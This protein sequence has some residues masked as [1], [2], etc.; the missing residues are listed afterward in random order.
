MLSG[1]GLAVAVGLSEKRKCRC[2][3]GEGE[4]IESWLCASCGGFHPE[5]WRDPHDDDD[6]DPDDDD[7][8]GKAAVGK[9]AADG[10]D[11][12]SADAFLREWIYKF[13]LSLMESGRNLKVF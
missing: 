5:K 3:L 4:Q 9:D 11:V 7:S 8:D 13:E 2:T 12:P 10:A 6:D 1:F